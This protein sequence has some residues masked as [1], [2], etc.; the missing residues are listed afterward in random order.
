MLFYFW[1]SPAEYEVT[2]STVHYYASRILLWGGSS[3]NASHALKISV[4]LAVCLILFWLVLS[5]LPLAYGGSQLEKRLKILKMQTSASFNF[6]SVFLSQLVFVWLVSTL[7]RP[8]S[9]IETLNGPIVSTALGA[10]VPCGDG[11]DASWAFRLSLPLLVYFCFTCTMLHSTSDIK[12]TVDALEEAD[13]RRYNSFTRDEFGS[14]KKDGAV[15]LV[16][17]DQIYSHFLHT[18][19]IIVCLTCSV[20]LASASKAVPLIIIAL[21]CF[22]MALGPALFFRFSCSLGSV[23]GLRAVG[24]LLVCWTAIVCI[25]K[26]SP[27]SYEWANSRALFIGWICISAVGLFVVCLV[28]RVRHENWIATLNEAHLPETINS[29]LSI[30]DN[31]TI[32]D[33]LSDSQSSNSPKKSI[34]TSIQ[35]AKS[36]SVVCNLMVS[37]ERRILAERLTADF[38]SRRQVWCEEVIYWRFTGESSI[39][40][41]QSL[42][43]VLKGGIRSTN[44]LTLVSRNILSIT[45][46]RKCPEEIAWEIFG[47]LFD[48]TNLRK[49]LDKILKEVDSDL[50]YRP[51]F[52]AEN[53]VWKQFALIRQRRSELLKLVVHDNSMYGK[54]PAPAVLSNIAERSNTRPANSEYSSF[55]VHDIETPLEERDSFEGALRNSEEIQISMDRQLAE[56]L[57]YEN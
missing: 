57:A 7:L 13:E 16:W 40:K 56:Q 32:D 33:A 3:G 42:L 5:S 19:Q 17:Y 46:K 44:P 45:F 6:I 21:S 23:I 8:S 36:F 11:S 52:T 50:K 49:V 31:L 2:N 10:V 55:M 1:V 12:D 37:L 29:L 4:I 38:L 14:E 51:E 20:G 30:A 25:F 9:C 48:S 27:D 39:L 54:S 34:I 43:A 26:T 53:M 15:Q 35:S 41:L 24:S 28:E 22:I 18:F 47:Y